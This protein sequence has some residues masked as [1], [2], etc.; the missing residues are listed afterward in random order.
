MKEIKRNDYKTLSTEAE[1]KARLQDNRNDRAWNSH[2]RIETSR[3]PRT[4]CRQGPCMWAEDLTPGCR[5]GEGRQEEWGAGYGTRAWAVRRKILKETRK[6]RNV[7]H[8][9][10]RL[11]VAQGP[12][13]PA[14]PRLRRGRGGWAWSRRRRDSVCRRQLWRGIC[15][16]IQESLVTEEAT[17]AWGGKGTRRR[18]RLQGALS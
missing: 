4:Y 14:A 12:A 11:A 10:L 7:S 16:H 18:P 13:L 15:K 9:P 2:T 3:M 8:H 1:D 17:G 5:D 6:L